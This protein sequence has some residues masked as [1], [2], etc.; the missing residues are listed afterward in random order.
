MLSASQRLRF[1]FPKESQPSVPLFIFLPGMDGTGQLYKTQS[2]GLIADF[3]IRCLSIPPDDLTDWE[4]LVEQ[5]AN[6]IEAEQKQTAH[7]LTY[8][9]GESFGGCLALKLVAHFPHL[10]DRLILVNPAS[11]FSRKS[12][13]QWGASITQWLPD[14]LYRLS[15]KGLLPFL[16]AQERVARQNR[17]AL[18]A[19][20]QSVTSETAAWRL[21]LLSQFA[22]EKLPLDRIEQPVLVIA[23]QNDRLLPSE[24]EAERLVRCL[25]KSQKILLPK[26]GHACLLETEVNLG[27]ILGSQRFYDDI[28]FQSIGNRL[29]RK[30]ACQAKPNKGVKSIF[31]G[32]FRSAFMTPRSR[33]SGAAK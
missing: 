25:P 15:A 18:L 5:L 11:S 27:E 10:C 9:C 13:M 16:I 26:S 17:Q 30:Y 19:A 33:F 8:I 29:E 31:S 21:S 24:E 4:G 20:M 28:W 1:L 23:S 22:L 6:L 14:S 12:W 32:G 3:D 7:R 2:S